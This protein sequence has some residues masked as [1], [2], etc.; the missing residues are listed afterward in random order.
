MIQPIIYVVIA[1]GVVLIAAQGIEVAVGGGFLGEL[2]AGPAGDLSQALPDAG[3]GLRRQRPD[4]QP[5]AGDAASLFSRLQLFAQL[6]VNPQEADAQRDQHHTQRNDYVNQQG[7]ANR[8]TPGRMGVPRC[9]DHRLLRPPRLHER[10]P[11]PPGGH[12]QV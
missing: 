6:M 5:Q 2:P 7:V 4:E 10:R 1:L 12:H 9:G 8:C 3:G 11:S